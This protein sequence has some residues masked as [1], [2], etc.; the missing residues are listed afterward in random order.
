MNEEVRY[1][2]SGVDG[3]KANGETK[4][5]VDGNGDLCDKKQGDGME[6]GY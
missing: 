2:C 3:R 5:D 6:V 1:L 4:D